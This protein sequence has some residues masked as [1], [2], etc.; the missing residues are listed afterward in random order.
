M[1]D[2]ASLGERLRAARPRSKD[3]YA[4]CF[5]AQMRLV[6][7]SGDFVSA[8]CSRR[9]GKSEGIARLIL[10]EAEKHPVLYFTTTRKEA[11]RIMWQRL[12]DVCEEHGID[13]EFRE[14]ELIV[15]IKGRDRIYLTGCNNETEI[16]KMRGSGWGLVVG[17]ESQLFPA[18]IEQLVEQTLVPATADYRGRIF[19]LGTPGPVPNGYFYATTTEGSSWSRHAWNATENPHL[20]LPW[21]Q[22]LA[23]TL[24]R[25]GITELHP[26]IQREFFGRW[27]HDGQALVF[28]WSPDCSF[29]LL[30]TLTDYVLGVDLGFDDADAICVLGWSSSSPQ[31]YLV[32]EHVLA[33]QSITQLTDRLQSLHKKYSPLATVVDTGGLGKKIADEVGRRTGIPLE[34]AEKQRKLEHV[35]L[36]NDALRSGRFKARTSS[37]FAQDAKRVEWDRSKPEQPKI[38]DRF[39]SDI[40]DAVLY[41]Y[42][43]A[44]HWLHEEP[45]PPPPK[46]G[47]PEYLILDEERLEEAQ[48]AIW[49]REQEE[50]AEWT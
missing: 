2:L 3:L 34:A 6:T 48:E 13:A 19:L 42:R 35:E 36:L 31:L 16:G 46:P 15:R 29:E 49:K 38:S 1:T 24:K 39:H 23:Q 8:C 27:A 5:P 22:L 18:Y 21:D 47:T 37:Q 41:A 7:D 20:E 26:S 50:N 28:A 32:E 44:L 17:D 45:P 33:K 11:K 30:P 14:A 9:A 10:T 43:R 12:K 40:C 25:R 4:D